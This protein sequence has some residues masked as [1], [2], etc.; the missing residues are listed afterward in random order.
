MECRKNDNH[1][2][3][4]P[5]PDGEGPGMR[6]WNNSEIKYMKHD[7]HEKALPSTRGEGLGMR[8][9]APEIVAEIPVCPQAGFL[10]PELVEGRKKI[11]AYLSVDKQEARPEGG[12]HRKKKKLKLITQ[13]RL[14]QFAACSRT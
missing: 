11:G 6:F 13:I 7:S 8:S 4:L 5:S 14:Q 9:I 3:V 2:V 1:E 12:A 10:L